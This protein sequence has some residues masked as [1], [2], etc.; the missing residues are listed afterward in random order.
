MDRAVNYRRALLVEFAQA[1]VGRVLE[2]GAGIGQLSAAIGALTS[3]THVASVEPDPAFCATFRGLHPAHTLVEGTI[4][5]VGADEAWDALVSINV[6]EHVRDDDAELV[7]FHARL[8]ARRGRLCLFVPAR[9]EIYSLLDADFGHVRRYGKPALRAQLE[10][11]G[12]EVERLHYFNWVGYLAWW[13]NFRLLKRRHFEPGSVAFFD[14][15]IFPV[16]HAC[17]RRVLRPP[18]GQSLLAIARARP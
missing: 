16:V 3:V 18:L 10:R 11:A 4:D 9:R 5:A 12:F 15:W 13:W 6:L 17:E 2:V 8:L 7:R 14:R 1:L